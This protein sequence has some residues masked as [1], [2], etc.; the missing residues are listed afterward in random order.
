MISLC[1]AVVVAAIGLIGWKL[2]AR[3]AYESA[4]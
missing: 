3:G 4:E 2:T 1:V